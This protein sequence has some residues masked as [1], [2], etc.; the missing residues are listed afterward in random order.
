MKF[1]AI[2]VLGAGVTKKGNLTRVCRSR[3]DKA[4]ELFLS[5]M[6]PRIIVAGKGEACVMKSYAVRKGLT[7][8]DILEEDKSLDTVGNAFFV[9]RDF[10]LRNDW[11]RLAVVTSGFH[12]RRAKLVFRKVFGKGYTLTFVASQ[13]VLLVNAFKKKL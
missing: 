12:L 3:V 4:V 9:K 7:E 8:A 1:D 5:G 13:S 2:V 6:A 10:L 11:H